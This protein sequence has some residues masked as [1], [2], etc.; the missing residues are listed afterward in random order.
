MKTE[1]GA[2]SA[3]FVPEA[4]LEPAR[5]Q[6]PLDFK[7]N[8]STN[9]TTQAF[10]SKKKSRPEYHGSGIPGAGNGTRTRDPDLGK[11]VLYQL[12]Y[13]RASFGTANVKLFLFYKQ[14]LRKFLKFF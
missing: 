9:S 12:S 5:P 14:G 3:F 6:W 2:V 7:S 10:V 1:K 13:S 4:G 8:V 11:V